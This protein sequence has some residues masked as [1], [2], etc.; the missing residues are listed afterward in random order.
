MIKELTRLATHL[1][2]KGLRKEADYLDGI[3][4]KIAE[5]DEE[6]EAML[7]ALREVLDG[8][9]IKIDRPQEWGDALGSIELRECM[10]NKFEEADSKMMAA[11]SGTND[12]RTGL[13]PEQ[14][15]EFFMEL[16]EDCIK[17]LDQSG[18]S[19][20]HSEEH[21]TLADKKFSERNWAPPEADDDD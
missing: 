3:I 2:A 5:V 9:D 10:S 1:D 8:R 20:W 11:L 21:E 15:V 16:R 12:L 14:L 18:G 19:E 13:D 6:E 17:E 4:K 7:A